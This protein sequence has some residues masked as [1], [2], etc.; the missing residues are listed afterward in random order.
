MLAFFSS[1]LMS[2]LTPPS[3]FVDALLF[4]QFVILSSVRPREGTDLDPFMATSPAPACLRIALWLA[5]LRIPP[6]PLPAVRSLRA[7][8]A[9][10]EDFPTLPPRPFTGPSMARSPSRSALVLS[11]RVAAGPRGAFFA[12]RAARAT[13]IVVACDVWVVNVQAAGGQIQQVAVVDRRNEFAI[14]PLVKVMSRCA[15]RNMG[16]WP[17]GKECACCD[18]VVRVSR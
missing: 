4:F 15:G 9:G 18:V 12:A 11:R 10:P 6:L 3:G 8:F 2:E 17:C 5:A 16:W 7:F 14:C 13:I 1:Q